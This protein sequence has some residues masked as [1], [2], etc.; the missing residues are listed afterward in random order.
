MY[1]KLD[2]LKGF[3]PKIKDPQDPLKRIQSVQEAL[4]KVCVN[5]IQ[6]KNIPFPFVKASRACRNIVI[7]EEA[8]IAKHYDVIGELWGLFAARPIYYIHNFYNQITGM[9]NCDNCDIE[10]FAFIK[11]QAEELQK[12]CPEKTITALNGNIFKLLNQ[13]SYEGRNLPAIVELDGME[14]LPKYLEKLPELMQ[15]GLAK[16]KPVLLAVTSTIGRMKGYNQLI[17]EQERDKLFKIARDIRSVK[18]IDSIA[19]AEQ[20]HGNGPHYP[21]RVEIIVFDKAA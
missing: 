21:M 10:T 11:A 15:N 14:T 6:C 7:V 12:L 8:E 9:V 2:T 1:I 16:N 4:D 3:L 13:A 19:Y 18:H 5:K 20:R 17:Y